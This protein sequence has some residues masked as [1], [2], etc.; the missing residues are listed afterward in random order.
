[1]K[2]EIN[3]ELQKLL[4]SDYKIYVKAMKACKNS[5]DLEKV[6]KYWTD[7]ANKAREILNSILG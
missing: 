4:G 3:T 5:E 7:R 6:N 1:M 2:T